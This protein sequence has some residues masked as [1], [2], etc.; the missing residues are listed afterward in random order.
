MPTTQPSVFEI[1]RV[2]RLVQSILVHIVNTQ[3]THT[4]I[5]KYFFHTHVRDNMVIVIRTGS[6]VFKAVLVFKFIQ[7]TSTTTTR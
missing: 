2:P 1:V 5:A 4:L 6:R 3:R 7:Q